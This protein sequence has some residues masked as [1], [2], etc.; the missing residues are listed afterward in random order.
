MSFDKIRLITKLI[1]EFDTLIRWRTISNPSILSTFKWGRR[2][3]GWSG[4]T[5]GGEIA[6]PFS[7][8]CDNDTRTNIDIIC[9][10][11]QFQRTPT[12]SYLE[13]SYM[14]KFIDLNTVFVLGEEHIYLRCPVHVLLD[15]DRQCLP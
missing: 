11:F 7:L 4:N 12:R 5:S 14:L 8:Q 3:K 15:D 2:Q 9:G 10:Y 13:R 6:L 1:K